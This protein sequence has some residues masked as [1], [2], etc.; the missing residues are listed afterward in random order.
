MHS[1]FNMDNPVINCL[2]KLFDCFVLSLCWIVASFPIITIGASCGALYRTVYRSIRRDEGYPLRMFWD[3]YRKNLK[4][5]ILVWLPVCA[6]YILLFADI[7]ILERLMSQGYS[8]GYLSIILWV[9]IGV[10]TMLKMEE[11]QV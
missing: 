7:F 6:V 10:A 11:K 9:L 5:C 1:L 2:N 8:M 3:T 4:I